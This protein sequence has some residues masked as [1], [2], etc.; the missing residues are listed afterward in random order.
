MKVVNIAT[1]RRFRRKWLSAGQNLGRRS[2]P[3]ANNRS[4][5][6]SSIPTITICI[7]DQIR[8]KGKCYLSLFSPFII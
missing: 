3:E 5:Y 6:I 1:G 7:T 4:Q 2:G 8:C